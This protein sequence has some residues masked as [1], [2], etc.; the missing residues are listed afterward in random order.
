[1]WDSLHNDLVSDKKL[2]IREK[3]GKEE[4][5]PDPQFVEFPQRGYLK[6]IERYLSKNP[7]SEVDLTKS[8]PANQKVP[9]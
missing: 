1:M 5:K 2:M 6:K 7:F 9:T 8:T 3:S 4:G